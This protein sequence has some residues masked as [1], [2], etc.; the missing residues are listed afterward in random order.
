MELGQETGIRKDF[1][2]ENSKSWSS[3]KPIYCS[4]ERLIRGEW[5]RVWRWP[6]GGNNW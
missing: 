3:R 5:V 6:K 1:V 2:K 4:K